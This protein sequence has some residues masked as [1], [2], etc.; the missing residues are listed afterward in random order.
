M[1]TVKVKF[2][3]DRG[4][5]ARTYGYWAPAEWECVVGDTL[6]VDSPQ[7]GLT[8]VTVQEVAPERTPQALVRAV[9][10]VDVAEWARE[11]QMMQNKAN[12]EKRIK[13]LAGS[14]RAEIPV[15]E[16]AGR[17]NRMA[18]LLEEL[19]MFDV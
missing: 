14:L 8:A 1:H 11:K 17:D 5:G 10:K 6:L 15:E 2:N 3:H 7:T 4:Y 12:L 19:S 13:T 18:A 9:C 16:L